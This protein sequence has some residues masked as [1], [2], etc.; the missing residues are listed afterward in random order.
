MGNH[1]KC[2]VISS[3]ILQLPWFNSTVYQCLTFSFCF[4]CTGFDCRRFYGNRT[5]N[6]FSVGIKRV[7]AYITADALFFHIKQIHLR[8]IFNHLILKLVVSKLF[9]KITEQTA[10]VIKL[11]LLNIRSI[12]H[13]GFVICKKCRAVELLACFFAGMVKCT[14]FNQNF[15]SL[16]VKVSF[17]K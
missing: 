8:Q 1:S 6:C 7:T 15:N 12:R 16:F 10:F 13:G 11:I 4:L 2:N 5:L 3:G 17:S 14:R 9:G